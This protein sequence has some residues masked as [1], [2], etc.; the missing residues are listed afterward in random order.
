MSYIN[1]F[2]LFMRL[3]SLQIITVRNTSAPSVMNNEEPV[4]KPI[5]A[6]SE[7]KYTIEAIYSTVFLMHFFLFH[8][9]AILCF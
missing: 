9:Q 4:V 1:L 6:F 8:T 2:L 3:T 7:T 5:I